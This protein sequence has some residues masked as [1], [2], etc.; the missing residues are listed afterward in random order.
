L[1]IIVDASHYRDSDE[2]GQD[3]DYENPDIPTSSK[4]RLA[5]PGFLLL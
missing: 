4:K 2:H 3:D 1:S 5:R